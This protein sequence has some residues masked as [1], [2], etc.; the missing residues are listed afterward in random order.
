MRLNRLLTKHPELAK[1]QTI[2]KE[3]IITEIDTFRIPEYKY[4]TTVSV[5]DTVSI[6]NERFT[7][8]IVK[9]DTIYKIKT[10]LK[11]FDVVQHDTIM[12]T[13]T[14]TVNVFEYKE[15]TFK[16]KSMYRGQGMLILLFIILVLII[17]WLVL[18]NYLKAQ[19][20]FLNFLK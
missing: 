10:V 7:I 19:F 18:K 8:Q 11:P 12:Y 9:H 3:I 1:V 14:D 13:Y 17:L 15:L 6:D 20:P 5:S 4:D 2:E 16:E